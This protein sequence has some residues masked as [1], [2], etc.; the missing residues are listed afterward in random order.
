MKKLTEGMLNL[1]TIKRIVSSLPTHDEE[2]RTIKQDVIRLLQDPDSNM[3]RVEAWLRMLV[4]SHFVHNMP[5]EDAIFC[6]ESLP[7]SDI[8]DEQQ[9]APVREGAELLSS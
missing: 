8:V 4:M 2:S 5:T 6:L 3:V 9:S 1:D 7:L